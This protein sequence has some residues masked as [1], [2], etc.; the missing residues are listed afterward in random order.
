M[1]ARGVIS[2]FEGHSEGEVGGK[3]GRLGG[4][5]EVG[6]ADGSVVAFVAAI[7]QRGLEGK[8]APVYAH[9]VK[10]VDEAVVFGF[11][12]TVGQYRV[13]AAPNAEPG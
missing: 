6:V 1:G 7:A 4:D 3:G 10:G 9:G 11:G 12:A 5:S 2:G 13:G 8:R